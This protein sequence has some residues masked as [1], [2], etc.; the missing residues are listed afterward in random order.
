MSTTISDGLTLVLPD[1]GD[2]NWAD[3]IKNGCF[4]PISSHDH[5]GSGNGLQLGSNALVTG[6]VTATKLADAAL[7]ARLGGVTSGGSANAQT[8][9]CV[10]AF[11]AF[12]NGQLLG[13]K[14][15]YTNTGPC[16][17]AVN[18]VS[19]ANIKYAL[20]GGLIPLVANEI[21]T[22][23]NYLLYYQ[24]PDWIL[25]NPSLA[26]RDWTPTP[27]ASG[28]MT[29]TSTSIVLARYLQVD[30]FVTFQIRISGTIGGTPSTGLRFTLP[31]IASAANANGTFS[32][33]YIDA[34]TPYAATGAFQSAGIGEITRYD[35]SNY[36]TGATQIIVANGTYE[37]A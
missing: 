26:W 2:T 1:S 29:Y 5:T 27:S 21:K 25:L 30:N 17:M 6:A 24:A 22:S 31:V 11:T 12:T 19:V 28:S 4:V 3:S 33:Q 13:F 15:G 32:A 20:G 35:F 8:L 9:T 16:T 14:A 18:G 36:P 37:A 34:G 7:A 10:P 23:N